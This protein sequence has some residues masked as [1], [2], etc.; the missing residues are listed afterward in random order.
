[1]AGWQPIYFVRPLWMQS[2]WQCSKTKL[3][4]HLVR[5]LWLQ[6]SWLYSKRW[7]QEVRGIESLHWKL[8]QCLSLKVKLWH[9]RKTVNFNI[10]SQVMW[11]SLQSICVTSPRWRVV[12]Y[13]VMNSG[14]NFQWFP[15][16]ATIKQVKLSLFFF[17]FY[18]QLNFDDIQIVCKLDEHH[19]GKS[20]WIQPHAKVKITSS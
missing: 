5:P 2:S 8:E 17:Y 13:L 20:G 9:W 10:E 6:L 14:W 12:H 18:L 16:N 3:H 11:Y 4:F 19:N 1:M 7:C 15:T